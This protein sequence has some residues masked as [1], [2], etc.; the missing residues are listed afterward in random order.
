MLNRFHCYAIDLRGA[1]D[2]PLSLPEGAVQRALS[3]E[4]DSEWLRPSASLPTF[5]G[6]AEDIC[7]IADHLK[8]DGEASAPR[9]KAITAFCTLGIEC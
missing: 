9:Q 7:A 6:H 8:W 3:I 5:E 2:S 4:V 1:G